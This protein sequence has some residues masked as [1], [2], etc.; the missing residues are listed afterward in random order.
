MWFTISQRDQQLDLVDLHEVRLRMQ[1]HFVFSGSHSWNGQPVQMRGLA[2]TLGGASECDFFRQR[3]RFFDLY[4]TWKGD[5]SARWLECV[6]CRAGDLVV[7]PIGKQLKTVTN[8][9][10]KHRSSEKLCRK[11]VYPLVGCKEIPIILP[12]A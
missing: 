11:G 9:D 8:C 12:H 1:V 6:W 7:F 3:G 10:D 4:S 5:C 2:T